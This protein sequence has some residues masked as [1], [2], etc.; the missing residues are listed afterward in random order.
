M[1]TNNQLKGRILHWKAHTR[2]GDDMTWPSYDQGNL[3][4][5]LRYGSEDQVLASRMVLASIV[6]AYRELLNL[7]PKRRNA[8]CK[9]IRKAENR[10][11]LWQY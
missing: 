7:P 1:T 8:I 5:R 9:A 6:A 2:V 3:E 11:L 4:W 10:K